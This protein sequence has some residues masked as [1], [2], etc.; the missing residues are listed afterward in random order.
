MQNSDII[1]LIHNGLMAITTHSL[2]AA[3]A[4]QVYKFKKLV[5]DA[6][7]TINTDEQELLKECDIEDADT[8]NIELEQARISDL[9][10]FEELAKKLQK[11]NGL[12]QSLYNEPVNVETIKP[13][14][15]ESWKKLQDENAQVAFRDKK[16]D[17]F[18]GPI[19]YILENILWV[20]PE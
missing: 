2:D 19:E 18:S 11:F 7:T 16:I 4:Y 20:S 10:K 8:F 5:L 14:S 15:Y 17:V 6:Y 1:T 3:D 13:L 12:R 9:E